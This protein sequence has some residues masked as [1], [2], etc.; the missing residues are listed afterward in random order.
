[1]MPAMGASE[2]IESLR[3]VPLFSGL[4]DKQLKRV[5]AAASERTVHEGEE[6]I[7]EGRGGAGF[8]VIESGQA[9]VSQGGTEIRRLGPGDSFGEMA[10][11]DNGPRSATIRAV[12]E[13]R[14][15]GLTAWQFRPIVEA[16]PEI[17]WALLETLVARLR[18]AESRGAAAG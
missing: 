5:A 16:N 8:F 14:C 15:H 4:S 13:L 17:A 7:V 10:L 3:R 6:I 12:S 9:S 18:D 11:V 1:M 2:M